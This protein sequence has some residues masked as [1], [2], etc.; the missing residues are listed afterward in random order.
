M[1]GEITLAGDQAK[2]SRTVED[3]LSRL[4]RDRRGVPPHIGRNA[5]AGGFVDLLEPLDLTCLCPKTPERYIPICRTRP[6]ELGPRS[7]R[8]VESARAGC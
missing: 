2:R 6:R 5:S 1:A 7:G 4:R 3:K 8:L